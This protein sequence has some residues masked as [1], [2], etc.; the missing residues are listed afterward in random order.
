MRLRCLALV[1]LGF[2]AL[3]AAPASAQQMPANVLREWGLIGWWSLRCQQPV[4]SNNYY[5]GY[6]VGA[7]GKV[8]HERDLGD[9]SRNDKSEVV[10]AQLLADGTLGISI[11]FTSINQI[12]YVIFTK[13]PGR[14]RALYNRGPS[15][16][17]T[18]E[19]GLFKHN[20][21]QTPWQY[22]CREAS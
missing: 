12:R 13:E 5:Y 10:S 19:N 17:L 18:V 2:L 11:N 8:Y 6:V 20:G 4:S 15:G 21:Q 14:I 16:D 22:K 1:A 3:F 7:D 9:P